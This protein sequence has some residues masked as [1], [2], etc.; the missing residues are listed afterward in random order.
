MKLP[1][2]VIISQAKLLRYLL[3]PREE[4]DKSQFLAAAGYTL[5]NWEVLERESALAREDA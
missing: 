1:E 5:S 4:N 3:L 2:N